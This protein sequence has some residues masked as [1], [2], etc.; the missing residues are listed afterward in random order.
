MAKHHT[1]NSP[2]LNQIRRKRHR[3]FRKRVI[4]YFGLI[5]ILIIGIS[6]I[7]RIQKININKIEISG[8]KVIDSAAIEQVVQEKISGKYFWLYPKTNFLFYPKY[9][10]K[11]DLQNNFKRL[12]SLSISVKNFQTLEVNVSEYEG[13]YLWC[14]TSTSFVSSID[15]KEKKCYFLDSRG[16]A[17]DES[18]YFSGGIYFKFYG[19]NFNNDL[20]DNN[21]IGSYFLP[22]NFEKIITFKGYLENMNFKPSAFWQDENADGNF[23][24][25]K[26]LS[27][28]KIIFKTD[29]DYEKIAENLESAISTEPLISNL[30]NKFSSLLYIDLRFGNKVYYKFNTP[31]TV[32]IKTP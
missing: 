11:K 16:Y 25:S 27:G 12:K 31:V 1:I 23:L 19:N 13:E 28:P 8:N 15:M 30:K 17:F 32:P 5:L 4:L 24:I 10:I 26:D 21:P 22:D 18:P 20:Q 3:A 9:S 14:G 6:F 29:S 7:S 2:R